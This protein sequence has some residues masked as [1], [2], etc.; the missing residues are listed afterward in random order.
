MSKGPNVVECHAKSKT[1]GNKCRQPVVPG[2]SVCVYHGGRAPQVQEAPRR[3][4]LEM[5][6]GVLWREINDPQR[7]SR[8]DDPMKAVGEIVHAICEYRGWPILG[9]DGIRIRV[10]IDAIGVGWGVAG[11]VREVC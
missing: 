8:H 7:R 1:S 5:A 4:L 9:E 3:R 10:N 2:A 11:R 6:D